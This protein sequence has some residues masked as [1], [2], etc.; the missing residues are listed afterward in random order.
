MSEQD[1][2]SFCG[3]GQWLGTAEVYSG[4]GEFLGN[5]TDRRHVRTPEGDDRL[6]IDLSFIGPLKFAGHYRILDEG[7][8]RIYQGPVNIGFAEAY[9]RDLVD[10]NA[11][12]PVT[13]LSQRFFLMLLPGGDKQLSL[14]LMARGD[15]LIYTI[16]SE[17]DRVCDDNG[18]IP[19][20]LNGTE[21][22]LKGDPTAGRGEL[23]LH[24]PGRWIGEL[25]TLDGE[26]EPSGDCGYVER[27]AATHTGLEVSAEG[28]PFAGG[29]I[30]Y[31]LTT[32]GRQAW[33][34]DGPV[35]GSYSLSGGRALTGNFH[36]QAQ[37]R[38]VWRREVV[39]HDGS[40]KAVVNAWY[41]GGQ[42]VGVEF[43]VLRFEEASR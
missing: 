31:Q 39:S 19:G 4:R 10:A 42:R 38:R 11:Y 33:T 16:V 41:R 43:G 22:D 32:N 5:A 30:R 20:L 7:K 29:A 8:D 25:T 17:N 35:V 36:V 9:G 6:R 40:V 26:R 1:N 28:S 15:E 24:R 34:P 18:P 37:R 12:W 27:V 14:S 13:G 3:V 2:A 23:L 21:Y